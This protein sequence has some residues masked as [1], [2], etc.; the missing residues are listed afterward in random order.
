MSA[1]FGLACAA[2][3]PNRSPAAA[4]WCRKT[5]SGAD[6]MRRPRLS[7][8]A[9]AGR[10]IEKAASVCGI[11]LPAGLN[12][13]RSAAGADLHA[14]HEG[15]NRARHQHFVRANG[16]NRRPRCRRRTAPP[17]PG[18]L[19]RAAP[20]WPAQ[21]GIIIADTKFEWG[22]VDGETHS[23]RRSAHARQFPLL[24]GRSIPARP[25][26][27]SFDK[28]FVRDWLETTAWDKNSPPPA[29]PDDVVV[30]TRR[31]VHRSLR[32]TDRSSSAGSC[33]VARQLNHAPQA[34]GLQPL[35]F[36]HVAIRPTFGS[37][38]RK[39]NCG[40]PALAVRASWRNCTTQSDSVY[41]ALPDRR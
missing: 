26:Q 41:V 2:S 29:L 33:A 17:Q 24:A 35:G 10:N 12:G 38:V 34:Q 28:Q 9:R 32:A 14:G 7:C 4:C 30:R 3:I 27:P 25:G 13:K 5:A 21:R 23:D 19:C 16:G 31:K 1:D 6:R 39:Y 15:R 37:S 11:R 18:D 36:F 20:S 22:R 8:R 40:L